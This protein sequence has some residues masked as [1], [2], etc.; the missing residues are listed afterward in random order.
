[1][2]DPLDPQYDLFISYAE[3]DR[4]W[5]EG[6]LLDAITQAG[7]RCTSEA[8][9]HLG[10]PRL[11]EFEHAV[12]ES[13][14]VLLV[15]S[16]AYF[17]D[18]MNAFVDLLATV[19]GLDQS[20]WPVVPLVLK[21]VKLPLRLKALVRLDATDPAGWPAV[22]QKLCEE[23]K[24]PV[25]AR[26]SKPLCPYPGMRPFTEEESTVFFGR[27][28]EVDDLLQCLRLHNFLAVIGR[29]GTGKS[30]LVFAGLVPALRKSTLFGVGNWLVWSIRPGETPLDTFLSLLQSDGVEPTAAA[31]LLTD[32]QAT[33]LLLVI[34]QFEEVFTLAAESGQARAFQESLL[35]WINLPEC[36]I[37]LAV[38]ADF[39]P[40]LMTC[41]LWP[42]I[43]AHRYEVVPLG[44][45]GL[46]EAI[47]LP[48]ERAQMYVEQSLVERLLNDAAD[49]PGML[50]LVQET[51][52]LLWEKLQRRFLP[53]DAYEQIGRGDRTGLQVAMAI[54]ANVALK[55]L[56]S[57]VHRAVARRIFLRLIQ[58]GEGRPDTRRQQRRSQLRSQGDDPAVFDQTLDHLINARLLVAGGQSTKIR[59]WTLLTSV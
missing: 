42:Q 21:R 51:M 46:S 13:K 41:P 32:A 24:R 4:S 23:L 30:S 25:P 52:V 34:D 11:H 59:P 58:F 37:V 50:P 12:K 47:V 9:L 40:D 49:E 10:Q 44:R 18:P 39:Y 35:R 20:T 5:A 43:Q 45:E 26:P 22:I 54:R 16:P 48:A 33:H 31:K 53:V 38:R 1:M 6:Y 27:R 14:R 36:L 19:H 29:S 3:A 17:G 55:D 28:Q 2:A 15:L 56:P 7:I 57:D 8:A